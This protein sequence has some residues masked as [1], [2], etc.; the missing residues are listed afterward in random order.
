VV[1]KYNGKRQRKVGRERKETMGEEKGEK[2]FG[3]FLF[4]SAGFR[5]R[6]AFRPLGSAGIAVPP[7]RLTQGFSSFLAALTQAFIEYRL[8]IWETK[9]T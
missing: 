9:S 5:S 4:I 2:K 3:G 1:E 7:W 6:F 8:Y